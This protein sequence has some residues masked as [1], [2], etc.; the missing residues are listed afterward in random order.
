MGFR[1]VDGHEGKGVYSFRR[2]N[3][4]VGILAFVIDC[5][6]MNI[7]YALSLYILPTLCTT[8]SNNTILGVVK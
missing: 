5:V 6:I 2:G 8:T 1:T 7:A 3:V 4:V